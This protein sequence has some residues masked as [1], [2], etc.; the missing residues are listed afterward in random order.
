MFLGYATTNWTVLS[1][2]TPFERGMTWYIYK[3]LESRLLGCLEYVALDKSHDAVWSEQLGDLL[4]RIGGEI[5]SF[6]E[7]MITSPSVSNR[8]SVVDIQHLGMRNIG[9]Y[10]DAF[11]SLY[12]LDDAKVVANH[13]LT[14][15]YDLFPFKN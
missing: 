12:H 9:H 5:A 3:R 8:Q 1:T 13:G 10:R 6:F 2:P 15:E 14:P 11:S 7:G 4:V